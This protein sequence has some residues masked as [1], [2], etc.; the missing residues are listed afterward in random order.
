M[1]KQVIDDS[2]LHRRPEDIA[3]HPAPWTSITGPLVG[4][5]APVT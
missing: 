5:C 3:P 4:G 2:L 1:I